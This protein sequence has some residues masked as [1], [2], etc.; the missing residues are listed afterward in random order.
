MK[1]EKICNGESVEK[2]ASNDPFDQI[3]RMEEPIVTDDQRKIRI[4]IGERKRKKKRER[5]C[6]TKG[7][8]E[9]QR[10]TEIER[11]ISKKFIS[12]ASQPDVKSHRSDTITFTRS[13][14][15]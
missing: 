2:S 1:D 4:K 13:K 6:E 14:R 9:Q 12:L 3:Y 11:D 7:R 10:G 5:I 8:T 15:I